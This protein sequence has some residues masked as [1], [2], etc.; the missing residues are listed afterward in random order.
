LNPNFG[1]K[2][3]QSGNS[4]SKQTES[5]QSTNGSSWNPKPKEDFKKR[6][7][8][9]DDSKV[10]KSYNEDREKI[11]RD[12]EEFLKNKGLKSPTN[13]ELIVE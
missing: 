4:K 5:K 1:K 12:R 3:P 13:N 11:K 6:E 2:T 7:E 10:K 9:V 8:K